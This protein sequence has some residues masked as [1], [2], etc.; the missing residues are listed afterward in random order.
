MVLN[1]LNPFVDPEAPAKPAAPRNDALLSATLYAQITIGMI[2]CTMFL[3]RGPA[4]PSMGARRGIR[5]ARRGRRRGARR[6]FEET[7]RCRWGIYVA[8]G[9]DPWLPTISN[10]W[11]HAP[12]TYISRWVVGNGCD[13]FAI[14]IVMMRAAE[15]KGR[16]QIDPFSAT[17][18]RRASRRPRDS[19]S[20]IFEQQRSSSDPSDAQVRG[21]TRRREVAQVY[22]SDG[23]RGGLLPVRGGLHL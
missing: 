4:R 23:P 6:A 7:I 15:R 11:D 2:V 14:M 17:L 22:L 1:P 21:P 18:P 9:G 19:V 12:G 16:L 5:D 8:K 20:S 10:T 3:T 13:M